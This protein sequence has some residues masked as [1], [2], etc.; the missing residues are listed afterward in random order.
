MET[1]KE[2]RKDEDKTQTQDE[3][4][5]LKES[6]FKKKKKRERIKKIDIGFEL[7]LI[8]HR[9]SKGGEGGE[10]ERQDTCKQIN[11]RK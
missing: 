8:Y 5:Q 9:D 11:K 10:K 4:K 7:C 2:G 6:E 1:K 3:R